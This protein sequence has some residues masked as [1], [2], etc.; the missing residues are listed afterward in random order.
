MEVTAVKEPRL[1]KSFP[2]VNISLSPQEAGYL[3]HI[4][5]AAADKSLGEYLSCSGTAHYG[6]GF[7]SPNLLYF[8]SSLWNKLDMLSE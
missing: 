2:R 6:V 1:G 8:K 7:T 3:W 4:L 5:N